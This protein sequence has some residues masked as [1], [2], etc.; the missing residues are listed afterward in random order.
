MF[1]LRRAAR[2]F[3]HE[4]LRLFS[5]YVSKSHML[6]ISFPVLQADSHSP[7]TS[8]PVPCSVYSACSLCFKEISGTLVLWPPESLITVLSI[9]SVSVP[10]ACS[11][12]HSL[13]GW[14][15]ADLRPGWGFAV[16]ERKR[17]CASSP[18]VWGWV[19]GLF[20]Q[21]SPLTLG[22]CYL[23]WWEKMI[24]CLCAGWGGLVPPSCLM[25]QAWGVRDHW[26]AAIY[27]LRSH[28]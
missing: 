22:M 24:P 23:P 13:W 4:S 6:S 8:S 27:H 9:N 12:K 11:L 19:E 7:L 10:S 18:C 21:V 14:I 28:T 5:S 25:L 15:A 16:R 3:N 26:I 2:T 17:H 20:F 1:F